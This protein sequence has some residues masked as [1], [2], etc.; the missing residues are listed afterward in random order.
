MS[1]PRQERN[2]IG[3]KSKT[4]ERAFGMVPERN[5]QRKDE[6][7][8]ASAGALTADDLQTAEAAFGNAVRAGVEHSEVGRRNCHK[9]PEPRSPRET[10]ALVQ[11]IRGSNIAPS[12]R[13]DVA[14]DC[15]TESI[16]RWKAEARPPPSTSIGI[17]PVKQAA[18]CAGASSVS[19]K[20]YT[21]SRGRLPRMGK[22]R[23]RRHFRRSFTL[24]RL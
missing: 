3:S 17:R 9:T 1:A 10:S 11:D 23:T 13:A 22:F 19:R 12:S 4:L 16:G 7:N 24:P 15:L 6:R 8:R 2:P 14:S 20:I 5:A 21:I 18:L